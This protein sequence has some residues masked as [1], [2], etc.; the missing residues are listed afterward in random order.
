M[1]G[2][3]TSSI[4]G[5]RLRRRR[6]A[7][8]PA[9][10]PRGQ[11]QA[12]DQPAPCRPARSA[13]PPQPQGT[14]PARLLPARRGRALRRLVP[15]PAERRVHAEHGRLAEESRKDHRPRRRLPAGERGGL[16]EVVRDR[17]CGP[18]PPRPVRLRRPRDLSRGDP[19]GAARRRA[20]LRG[21]R[22]L[23]CSIAGQA[24][25]DRAAPIIID[26][27]MGSSSGTRPLSIT[28][29]GRGVV[30]STSPPAI[31]RAEIAGRW[32]PSAPRPARIS[33]TALDIVR[34]S[35]NHP[36]PWPAG[37]LQ[38]KELGSRGSTR[39]PFIRM[40]AAQGSTAI[41]AQD[42]QGTNFSKSG[43]R[44]SAILRAFRAGRSIISSRDVRNA[45]Q[46][47]T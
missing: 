36:Y 29:S 16:E 9:P 4:V 35:G 31:A 12:G 18:P 17:A 39:P 43:S 45:V 3:W 8:H 2:L 27:K 41:R 38:E 32:R 25:T 19:P 46:C 5:P 37:R 6:A 44:R 47:S 14:D 33:A 42:P 1:S 21:D 13:A 10:P 26:A 11:G 7:A 23:L 24:R 20:G 34:G 30:L 40:S 28:R 22:S 15:R